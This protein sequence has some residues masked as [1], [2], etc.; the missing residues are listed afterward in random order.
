MPL[1]H[2]GQLKTALGEMEEFYGLFKS[3][4]NLPSGEFIEIHRILKMLSLPSFPNPI[5]NRL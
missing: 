5:F 3:G 4:G 1:E 2:G